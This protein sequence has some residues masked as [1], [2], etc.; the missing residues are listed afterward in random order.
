MKMCDLLHQHAT[1]RKSRNIGKIEPIVTRC[2]DIDESSFNLFGSPITLEDIPYALTKVLNTAK[3]L[4]KRL[5]LLDVHP[6]LT[7]LRNSLS[8]PRF[9]HVLRRNRQLLLL[10]CREDRQQRAKRSVLDT[11]L[12]T[13]GLCWF[14]RHT[15]RTFRPPTN[16]EP[17]QTESSRSSIYAF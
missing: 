13:H 17:C 4:C 10:H 14:N 7:L 12:S 6:A 11:G 9:Q 8:L 2:E 3:T 1:R 16:R 5:T 15:Q